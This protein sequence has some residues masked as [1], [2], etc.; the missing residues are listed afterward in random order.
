LHAPYPWWAAIAADVPAAFEK[1]PEGFI[2]Q[3]SGWRLRIEIDETRN[4]P[5][6]NE[7][8]V[9]GVNPGSILTNGVFTSLFSIQSG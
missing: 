9:K 7:S 5:D 2:D 1:S 8:I 6:V 3:Q 4:S